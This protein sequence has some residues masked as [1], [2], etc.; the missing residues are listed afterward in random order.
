MVLSAR[1]GKLAQKNKLVTINS[2]PK[3]GK[4]KKF[5]FKMSG[6]IAIFL[7]LLGF[8]LYSFSGQMLE[9]RKVK[10]EINEIRTQIN[11][12]QT[13]NVDLKKRVDQ[14]NSNAYIEREARQKLGLVKPGEQI[15]LEATPGTG[16]IE[17]NDPQKRENADVH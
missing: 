6:P 9:M 10:A 4:K 1:A 12:L 2:A 17:P 5:K 8:I 3:S 7:L 14:L 13:K 16:S 11:D 15:I